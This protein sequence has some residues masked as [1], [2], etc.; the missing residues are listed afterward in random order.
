[1]NLDKELKHEYTVKT[2]ERQVLSSGSVKYSIKVVCEDDGTVLADTT[3]TVSKRQEENLEEMLRN[4]AKKRAVEHEENI[5][6][7]HSNKEISL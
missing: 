2:G 6:K 5:G 7:D 3:Y 4:F 1:M